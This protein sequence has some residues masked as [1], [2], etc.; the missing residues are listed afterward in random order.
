MA[1]LPCIGLW[2]PLPSHPR[3][4][5][6]Y[7][8]HSVNETSKKERWRKKNILNLDL[9]P[10]GWR[11]WTPFFVGHLFL[12]H[13]PFS[14]MKIHP[15]NW[16]LFTQRT[17]KMQNLLGF[18]ERNFQQNKC[19]GWSPSLLGPVE[20]LSKQFF[21]RIKLHSNMSVSMYLLFSPFLVWIFEKP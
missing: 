3:S 14:S 21:Q 6:I 16:F 18:L 10:W 2:L 20:D 15:F 11:S 12:Q 19:W 4:C 13:I 8:H 9:N 5:A 1:Q 7:F 17:A